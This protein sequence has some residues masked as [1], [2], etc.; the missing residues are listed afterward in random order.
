MPV[1]AVGVGLDQNAGA[2]TYSNNRI[3]IDADGNYNDPDDWA[4]T[5]MELALLARRGLQSKLVH[6]SWAKHHWAQRS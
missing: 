4:A 6:Y 5:P 3:A 2:V 1:G